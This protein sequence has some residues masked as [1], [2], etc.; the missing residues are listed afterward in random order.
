[1]SI[2]FNQ[3]SHLSNIRPS[4]ILV[5][6]SLY[7]MSIY[8]MPIAIG[9]DLLLTILSRLFVL[10]SFSFAGTYR[11][12][13]CIKISLSSGP[14]ESHPSLSIVGGKTQF[15]RSRKSRFANRLFS[16][17]GSRTNIKSYQHQSD[18]YKR[19]CGRQMGKDKRRKR[20]RR[21]RD[22]LRTKTKKKSYAITCVH[23]Q[24]KGSRYERKGF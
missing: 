16:S 3:S 22:E 23:T 4:I 5:S 10:V 12:E 6:L 21:R 8:L 18:Q 7:W 1:M 24:R 15:Q 14:V 19:A 17:R 11:Y 9:N 13:W 2:R 20:Q